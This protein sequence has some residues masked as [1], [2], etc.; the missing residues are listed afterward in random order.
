MAK[1]R[2]TFHSWPIRIFFMFVKVY[3]YFAYSN[4]Q[5]ISR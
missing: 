3:K 4:Y 2:N 5:S 1:F